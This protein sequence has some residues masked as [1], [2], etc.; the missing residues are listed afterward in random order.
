MIKLQAKMRAPA[1][2]LQLVQCGRNKSPLKKYAAA[3]RK[4]KL[5]KMEKSQFFNPSI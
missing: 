3:A 1:F 5:Q 4:K 2:L